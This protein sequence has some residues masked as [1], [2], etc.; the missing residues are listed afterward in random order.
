M[1]AAASVWM[2]SLHECLNVTNI[3]H[4]E[5]SGGLNGAILQTKILVKDAKRVL[6][7]VIRISHTKFNND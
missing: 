1:L 3:V 5:E 7:H 6:M 4:F 2:N